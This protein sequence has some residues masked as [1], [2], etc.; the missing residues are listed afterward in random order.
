[1]G[2]NYAC[3]KKIFTQNF[4]KNLI[5]ILKIVC[6]WVSYK[7]KYDFFGSL[8]SLK[9]GVGSRGGS[10]SIC[11]RYGCGDPDPHQNVTGLIFLRAEIQYVRTGSAIMYGAKTFIKKRFSASSFWKDCY[12]YQITV[13]KQWVV[14]NIR[15]AFDEKN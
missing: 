5:L 3:K 13:R 7:K 12:K 9:K 1:V 11:Q 14:S 4:S 2:G 8:K 10:G 15:V 6:L